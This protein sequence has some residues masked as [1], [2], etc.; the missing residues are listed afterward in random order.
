MLKRRLEPA[1]GND[2][3]LDDPTVPLAQRESLKR[4]EQLVGEPATLMPHI[5]ILAVSSSGGN[6]Y[7]TLL[8]NHRR[9]SVTHFLNEKKTRMPQLDTLMVA[10]GVLGSYPGAFMKVQDTGL[11]A[12][13]EELGQ[14]QSGAD[15]SQLMD[16]YGIR[17]TSKGFWEHSDKVQRDY[18]DSDNYLTGLLDYNRLEN[19]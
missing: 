5:T 14:M 8:P 13:V 17:R 9:S 16:R 2:Y 7:Y 11:D 1:L 3:Q 4:L 10:R 18:R 12:F 15:Y 19:R 6:D